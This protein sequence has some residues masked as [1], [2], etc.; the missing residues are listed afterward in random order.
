MLANIVKEQLIVVLYYISWNRVRRS[1]YRVEFSPF[2]VATGVFLPG[3]MAHCASTPSP[4]CPRS[5]V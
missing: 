3:N 2:A 4:G 1:R 5:L